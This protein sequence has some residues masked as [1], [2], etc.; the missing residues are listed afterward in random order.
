M[1]YLL[2]ILSLFSFLFSLLKREEIILRHKN[3]NKG[4]FLIDDR[5]KRGADKF[6]GEHIHFG[7]KPFYNWFDVLDYLI[8]NIADINVRN[9]ALKEKKN[10][11]AFEKSID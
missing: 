7:H 3:L 8:K 2:I 5:T 9:M 1:R 11:E 4:D 10:K 6:D